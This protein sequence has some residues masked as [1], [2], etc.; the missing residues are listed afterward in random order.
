[1]RFTVVSLVVTFPHGIFPGKTFPGRRFPDSFFPDE[2]F[3]R[4]MIPADSYFPGHSSY[5]SRNG[6]PKFDGS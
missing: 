5:V 6:R 1:M 3:P 4:K 2:T